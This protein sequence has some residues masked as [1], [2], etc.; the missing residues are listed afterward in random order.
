MACLFL[1]L[2]CSPLLGLIFAIL[3]DASQTLRIPH[4]TGKKKKKRI[5][6]PMVGLMLLSARHVRYSLLQSI[7]CP[8]HL[9]LVGPEIAP[10]QMLGCVQDWLDISEIEK[11]ALS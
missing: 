8:G 4:G 5:F 11:E 10:P 9:R 6:F 7:L 1:C 3:A 2:P